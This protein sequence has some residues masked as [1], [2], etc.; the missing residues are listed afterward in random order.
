MLILMSS[1]SVSGVRRALM[2]RN[3]NVIVELDGILAP[4]TSKEVGVVLT[5]L[6]LPTYKPLGRRLLLV[7]SKG[8]LRSFIITMKHS[9]QKIS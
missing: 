9:S 4:L 1:I 8:R 2:S 5:S 7:V 3:G 6:H